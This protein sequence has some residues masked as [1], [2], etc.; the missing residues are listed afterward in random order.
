MMVSITISSP[1]VET[2]FLFLV[3]IWTTFAAAAG[4]IVKIA[5]F[6]FKLSPQL[7]ST[8]T[9]FLHLER[10]WKQLLSWPNFAH[11]LRKFYWAYGDDP[12]NG[13]DKGEKIMISMKW[14]EACLKWFP[15]IG[16]L[17]LDSFVVRGVTISLFLIANLR[18]DI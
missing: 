18:W 10:Y 12:G 1:F 15:L 8:A 17:Q 11:S 14:F 2:P 9:L 4:T 7:P 6:N 13:G 16:S 5:Q 3:A